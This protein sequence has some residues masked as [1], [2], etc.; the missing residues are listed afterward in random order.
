MMASNLGVVFGPTII[1]PKDDADLFYMTHQISMVENW[2]KKYNYFFENGV[3]PE[4]EYEESASPTVSA[5][6]EK[7]P[8]TS[9]QVENMAPPDMMASSNQNDITPRQS[10]Q[11]NHM[12]ATVMSKKNGS[13]P[14]RD[15]YMSDKSKEL[16]ATV[17]IDAEPPKEI[18]NTEDV[19]GSEDSFP[20]SSLTK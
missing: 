9:P 10:V 13:D 17:D 5:V 11:L 12:M 19:Q 4:I 7:K 3:V 2:I 1:R 6:A 18:A 16:T 8:V 15:S 20:E 14:T